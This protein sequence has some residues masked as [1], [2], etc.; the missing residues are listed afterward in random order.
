MRHAIQAWIDEPLW[1]RIDSL[2]RERKP[3][4]SIADF[5]RELLNLGVAA[6]ERQ[7][8]QRKKERPPASAQS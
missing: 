6:Y 1:D 7:Q 3:I 4:G 5:V 2:R 8:H